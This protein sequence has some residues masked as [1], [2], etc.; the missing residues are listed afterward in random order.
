MR[1]IWPG[2]SSRERPKF[3]IKALVAGL[4]ELAQC[5]LD[6]VE[7]VTNVKRLGGARSVDCLARNFERPRPRQRRRL[8]IGGRR[9]L[10]GLERGLIDMPRHLERLDVAVGE[11]KGEVAQLHA[12]SV[13][14][15]AV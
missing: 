10:P 8:R 7:E 5:R 14:D 4:L 13:S 15:E 9:A 3:E 2:A 12:G 1:A 11:D 6:G